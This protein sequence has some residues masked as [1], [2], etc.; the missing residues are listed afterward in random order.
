MRM[1]R[2]GWRAAPDRMQT[3]HLHIQDLWRISGEPL[4]DLWIILLND[5]FF[6][7]FLQNLLK[8]FRRAENTIINST[9]WIFV[10]DDDKKRRTNS[11]SKIFTRCYELLANLVQEPLGNEEDEV[12]VRPVV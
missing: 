11:I 5:L 10:N 6:L 2:D 9:L 3:T 7:S 1:W 8:N 12:L 4:E